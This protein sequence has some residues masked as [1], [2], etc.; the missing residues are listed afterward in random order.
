MWAHIKVSYY[1][2]NQCIWINEQCIWMFCKHSVQNQ[3]QIDG[4]ASIISLIEVYVC[5]DPFKK[6]SAIFQSKVYFS[7]PSSNILSDLRGLTWSFVFL[8]TLLLSFLAEQTLYPRQRWGHLTRER[9][10]GKRRRPRCW[11]FFLLLV[12]DGWD[13]LGV[14]PMHEWLKLQILAGK[15]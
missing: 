3:G 15:H 13:H 14:V 9:C 2:W 12:M 1:V 6:Y 4:L 10:S 5:R 7:P 8:G 11:D